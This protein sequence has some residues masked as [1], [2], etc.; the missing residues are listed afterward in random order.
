MGYCVANE[1]VFLPIHDQSEAFQL[2]GLKRRIL[3]CGSEHFDPRGTTPF[4]Y[5][6][7]LI[8]AGCW[9]ESVEYLLRQN[10]LVSAV[11]LSMMLYWYNVCPDVCRDVYVMCVMRVV[12]LLWDHINLCVSY[13]SVIREEADRLNLLV[14]GLLSRHDDRWLWW[15]QEPQRHW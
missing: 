12:P 4:T 1:T 13:C 9:R 14:V 5:V 8:I 3:E 6:E 11:N 15:A 10:L 7:N 2:E